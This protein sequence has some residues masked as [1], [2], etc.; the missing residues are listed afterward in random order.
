MSRTHLI[1]D[2]ADRKIFIARD[3]ISPTRSSAL[4]ES[5]WKP[6]G[7]IHSG[8]TDLRGRQTVV[9]KWRAERGDIPSLTSS[10]SEGRKITC[11]HLRSRNEGECALRSLTRNG[12]LIA[13]EEKQFI[14]FDGTTDRPAILVAF[15]TVPRW[16]EEIP[17]IERIVPDKLEQRTVEVV[18]ARAGNGIYSTPGMKPV[19]SGQ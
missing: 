9:H 17:G 18:G 19:L 16:R 7:N 12:A 3:R 1:V 2:L 11:N 8:R 15:Q 14:L 5:R 13:G 6:F 10:G 4:I